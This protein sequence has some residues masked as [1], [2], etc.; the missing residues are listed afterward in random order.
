MIGI[1]SKYTHTSLAIRQLVH[2]VKSQGDYDIDFKEYTINQDMHDI[3]G[4]IMEGSPDVLA[5]SCYIWNISKVMQLAEAIKKGTNRIKI[6]LGG[7]EV[8]Y[9]TIDFMNKFPYVDYIIRGEG[10]KPLHELLIK[11]GK[12][13][14][15]GIAGLTFRKNNEV[16]H[17]EQEASVIDMNELVY[18]YCGENNFS[19]QYIYYEAS[20]GC[21]FNCSF[22]ISSNREGVRYLS[23]DRV[24]ND[25]DKLM[26]MQP[27]TIKFVDRTF[28]F[29]KYRTIEILDYIVK[30]NKNHCK[31]H[32]ELTAEII[33]EE[34]LTYFNQ[35]PQDMFQFEIGVQSVNPRTL[36]EVGRVSNFEKLARVVN[37]MMEGNNAHI[38]L[39]LIAGLP[40]ENYESFKD[41][42]NKVYH[43]GA[44]K[45]QL[46]FLKVLKGTTI[47]K[48]HKDYQIE[49][50]DQAPYEVIK[51]QDMSFEELLSLKRIEKLVT[52]YYDES[53]FSNTLNLITQHMTPFNFFEKFSDY[54]HVNHIDLVS[55]KRKDLYDYLNDF[56]IN[57]I[58]LNGE[59]SLLDDFLLSERDHEIP[60]FLYAK[61]ERSWIP[62]KHKLLKNTQFKEQYFKEYLDVPN[63]K[64]VNHFRLI[65]K[66]GKMVAYLYGS[67]DNIFERSKRIDVT[68]FFEGEDRWQTI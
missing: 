54:W 22:C 21:P 66:G 17:N 62:Y 42:F 49:F 4:K 11:W 39:D 18:P 2:Y 1:N 10:E 56:M 59:E 25:L 37:R 63:K 12:G 27:K 28:N 40:G 19:N 24:K 61:D 26:K 20:R 6:L 32:L 14:L 3:L 31:I 43:L 13:S 47:H 36:Q 35:L 64:L 67:K 33:D 29:N 58:G 30:T 9:D 48:K 41:S 60:T 7:P 57:L 50:M 23:V 52:R 15:E 5:F 8:S 55:H 65:E 45:L 46:G 53:R 34:L 44:H 68:H 16:I 38:H 51:T